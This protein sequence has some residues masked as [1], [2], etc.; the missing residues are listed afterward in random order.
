MAEDITRVAIGQPVYDEDGRQLGTIRGFD[1][2]GFVVTARNGI[3]GLSI[4]HTRAGHEFGEATLMW[5]CSE[6]GEVGDLED[7]P[8][9]CPSCGASREYIYYS[10]ED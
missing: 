1:E 9:K 10:I 7:L 2:D 6:C 4:E 8:Q 5:R 3:E